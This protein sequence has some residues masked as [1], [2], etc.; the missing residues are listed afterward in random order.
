MPSL[1]YADQHE[2][3]ATPKNGRVGRL[4]LDRPALRDPTAD[5]TVEMTLSLLDGHSSST[6]AAAR[7]HHYQQYDHA[8][9]EGSEQ[10]PDPRRDVVVIRRR[11]GRGRWQDDFSGRRQL[12][13]F[14]RAGSGCRL[15]LDSRFRPRRDYLCSP[16][17]DDDR[18]G[19]KAGSEE[20]GEG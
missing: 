1:V 5:G 3:A 8:K 4:T 20:S 19:E 6:T 11:L 7:Q 16:S 12:N 18:G 14:G 17:A 15:G 13:G 9:S 2:V 10:Y